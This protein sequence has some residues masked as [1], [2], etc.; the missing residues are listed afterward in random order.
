M[1]IQKEYDKLE[2]GDLFISGTNLYEKRKPI[3]PAIPIAVSCLRKATIEDTKKYPYIARNC[4]KVQNV[5][6]IFL[7]ENEI[8]F[9]EIHD[10][11][12]LDDMNISIPCDK[13][14]HVPQKTW[15]ILA[16]EIGL[17]KIGSLTRELKKCEGA[18]IYAFRQKG[19]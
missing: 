7:V 12:K 14:L 15:M 10:S 8:K 6:R 5:I 9:T 17:K 19:S 13:I 11:F 18:E 16:M 3:P 4:M 2:V 1:D